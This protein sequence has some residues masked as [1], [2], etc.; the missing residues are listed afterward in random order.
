MMLGD[1]D[2]SVQR[3]PDLTLQAGVKTVL[4]LGKLRG[5]RV[6]LDGVSVTPDVV[7][8]GIC[9]DHFALL[10]Y[11]T[12]KMFVDPSPDRY[13]FRTRELSEQF[14]SQNRFLQTLEMEIHKLENGA[15]FS[16]WQNYFSWLSGM[17]GLPLAEVMTD[18]HVQAPLWNATLTREGM[19]QIPDQR[20]GPLG[21][22]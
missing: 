16:G 1:L 21:Q 6:D 2:P 22:R 7:G 19:R 3:Y 18:M 15:C 17:A 11:H 12:V 4:S 13:T 9:P 5:Y 8:A 20:M 10:C 14:G